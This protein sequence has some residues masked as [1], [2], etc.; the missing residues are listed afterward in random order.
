MD[1]SKHSTLQRR[2]LGVALTACFGGAQANPVAPQVAAGQASFSQQGN[3]FTVANAPNTII[4]WRS[5]SI[6]ADELTRFVQQGA[7]SKVLNRIT[8]QDPSR[9]LGSLQSNGQVYLLNPNGVLFGQGARIDVQGLVASSLALS[10]ADFLAGRLHFSGGAG[11]GK[12]AHQGLINT[13]QGGQVYLVAPQVENSGIIHAPGGAVMLAAGHSVQLVDSADPALQV[14]LSAPSDQALNLGQVVAQGGRIGMFGALVNQRGTVSADSAVRGAQ[15]QVLLRASGRTMLEGGSRTTARGGG[16]LAVLGPQVGLVGDARLDASGEA[17]GGSVLVGGDYRGAN[18]QVPNA[19]Q[20]YVGKDVVLAADALSSGKGGKV[21]V[22]ADEVASVQGSIS[23]RGGALGGDGGLVETSAHRLELGGLRVDAGAPQ[24]RRGQWL[25]DPFDIEV[26]LTPTMPATLS[27]VASFFSGP[28]TGVTELATALLN[29]ASA[30]VT[31]Q[32]RHDITFVDPVAIAAPGVGLL[33]Q[34][35]NHIMVKGKLATNGGMLRLQANDQAS[36]AAS[37]SGAVKLTAGIETG[38]GV[39]ELSGAEIEVGAGVLL[40][41]QEMRWKAD[42]MRIGSGAQL[43]A[44]NSV[45]LNPYHASTAIKLGQASDGTPGVLGLDGAELA[46][47]ITQNLNIGFAQHGGL[48][49]VE[50]MLDLAGSNAGNALLTLASSA[51]A[52][53]GVLKPKSGLYLQTG[54]AV[55]GGGAIIAPVLLINAGSVALDGANQVMGL[56]ASASGDISFS[57]IGNLNLTFGNGQGGVQTPG[58]VRLKASSLN[59]DIST[60]VRAASLTLDGSGQVNLGSSGNQ[61]GSLRA[62][63]VGSLDYVDSGTLAVLALSQ[64]DAGNAAGFAKLRVRANDLLINGPV[65]GNGKPVQLEGAS[66]RLARTAAVSGGAMLLRATNGSLVSEI[67]SQLSGGDIGLEANAMSLAGQANAAHSIRVSSMGGAAIRVGGTP[68]N[69]SGGLVLGNADLGRL[70]APNLVIGGVIFDSSGK[71]VFHSGNITADQLDLSG[72]AALTSLVLQ[73]SGNVDLLG[74]LKLPAAA[75][76]GAEAGGILTNNAMVSAHSIKV[77]GG[78]VVLT[79]AAGTGMAAGMIGIDSAGT[80]ELGGS[81][82]SGAP[83]TYLASNGLA[84]LA[85]PRLFITAASGMKVGGALNLPGRELELEARSGLLQVAA[86]LQ[87]DVVHL[88]A[89]AMDFTADVTANLAS[90]TPA[91][92]GHSISIGAACGTA[93]LSLTQ[94]NRIAAATVG[95]GNRDDGSGEPMPGT[96][97]GA[98]AGSTAA[99][100]GAGSNFGAGAIHIGGA[101]N[102][103]PLTTRLGL[104]TTAGIT[105]DSANAAA[106][107]KVLELGIEAGGNVQLDHSGNQVAHIAAVVSSGNLD[108]RSDQALSVLRLQGGDT[109]KGSGYDING[110]QVAGTATLR[111]DGALATD[112]AAIKANKLVAR[113]GANIGSAAAALQT[114]VSE[115][116]AESTAASGLAPIVISNNAGA[117]APLTVLQLKLASGNGGAIA[118]DNYGPTTLAPGAL[119]NSDSGDIRLSAHSPLSIYGSVLSTSG[120]ILLEAGNSGSGGDNLLIDGGALVKSQQGN[121]TLL[122]ATQVSYAPGTV[123]APGGSIGVNGATVNPPTI[124]PTSIDQCQ[125]DPTLPGCQLVLPPT[126]AQPTNPVQAAVNQTIQVINSASDGAAPGQASLTSAPDEGKDKAKKDDKSDQLSQEKS[127]GAKQHDAPAKMYCN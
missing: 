79:G 65:N 41:G 95:I 1:Y 39:I 11:A 108:F 13:P 34:A 62:D 28:T 63:G 50:G 66:L 3:V 31:L 69:E 120:N 88:N 51:I 33:A 52:V 25:L 6:G 47:I 72:S 86:P 16:A 64:S 110:V 117:P 32:A 57:N 44:A 56:A 75:G 112:G 24:G 80:I 26:K 5:F 20:V 71:P 97:P 30:D 84:T 8:G 22:W 111:S 127:S 105:Q 45:S 38:I 122:A 113:S 15:G 101:A 29:G 99:D 21:I 35:G 67:G 18:P 115:L 77:R 119:V 124:P 114:F 43:Q 123:Q 102:L 54:G 98:N 53:N 93:C 19:R 70:A 2:L 104:L 78:S 14:V 103:N 100:T 4:N 96:K 74:T 68:V 87:A 109:S 118:L 42:S 90:L 9:I 85:T 121:V 91:T 58:N 37:G 92:A 12:V 125:L 76:L 49:S 10:D 7:G 48:L 89:D 17:G 94:L 106:A 27:D 116:D 40:A 73:T 126:Q 81:A 61:V 36:G 59:Q 83:T 55:S 23:A 60:P 107:L 82:P 46:S